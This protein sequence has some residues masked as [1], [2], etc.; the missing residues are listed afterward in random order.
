MA[1]KHLALALILRQ[2][3]RQLQARLGG[4]NKRDFDLPTYL[5]HTADTS[6]EASGTTYPPT[7][8]VTL[9]TRTSGQMVTRGDFPCKNGVCEYARSANI[10]GVRRS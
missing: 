8:C 5:R 1:G 4:A 9:R 6:T 2:E 10:A 7:H 3:N